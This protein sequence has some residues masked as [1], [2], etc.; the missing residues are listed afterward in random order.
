MIRGSAKFDGMAVG[1]GTF[2]FIRTGGPTLTAKAAFIHT[3]TGET[4]GWTENTVWSAATLQKLKELQSMME[5]DLGNLHLDNG[6]EVL[7]TTSRVVGGE[8]G[9]L[10]DHLAEPA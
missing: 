3:T 10:G 4:H 1:E 6:G 8:P 2:N 5:V 7:V 9:G